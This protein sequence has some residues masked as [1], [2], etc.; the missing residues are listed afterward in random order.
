M[1]EV[2]SA[3]QTEDGFYHPTELDPMKSKINFFFL[4]RISKK[5]IE[6]DFSPQQNVLE[7]HRRNI[8][9]LHCNSERI[10]VS[11]CRRY[12]YEY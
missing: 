3:E 6:N 1:K 10:T 4:S 12:D 7:G 2:D 5:G 9:R 8:C 11:Y